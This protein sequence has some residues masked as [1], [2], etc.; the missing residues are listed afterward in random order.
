MWDFYN[1]DFL[2]DLIDWD[3]EMFRLF[4]IILAVVG[5]AVCLVV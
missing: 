1:C 4:V 3:P 5:L 2:F